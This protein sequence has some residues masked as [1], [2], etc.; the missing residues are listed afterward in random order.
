[1]EATTDFI[2]LLSFVTNSTSSIRLAQPST[3]HFAAI[4]CLLSSG[5]EIERLIFDELPVDYRSFPDFGNSISSS[6][7][8][9]SL[10][11]TN[12]IQW[13]W[14]SAA[15]IQDNPSVVVRML[16]NALRSQ[17]LRALSI[18]CVPVVGSATTE[19]LASAIS[20]SESLTELSLSNCA[21]GVGYFISKLQNIVPRLESL[22]LICN[23]SGPDA[24]RLLLG[25]NMR[26]L[27]LKN[28]MLE[29]HGGLELG[30]ALGNCPELRK[31]DLE[32]AS[33]TYQ[34]GVIDVAKGMLRRSR[35]R[36]LRL[37][38]LRLS[39][40]EHRTAAVV[41]LG[42]VFK[43]CPRLSD[44]SICVPHLPD[45][46]GAR[47]CRA[48]SCCA[49]T[50][51]R[52]DM[53]NCGLERKSLRA[54]ADSFAGG[55]ALRHLNLSHNHICLQGARKLL[56]LLSGAR[57]LES[58]S[59]VGC[60]IKEDGAKRLA[61]W[62]EDSETELKSLD[63]SDNPI[64]TYGAIALMNVIPPFQLEEINISSCKIGDA[65]APALIRIIERAKRLRSVKARKN[66]MRE[67]W[68]KV[69]Q[70]VMLAVKRGQRFDGLDLH[71]N[72]C[73]T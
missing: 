72:S 6:A 22:S 10:S 44:L 64:M 71:Y 66:E 41:D 35:G 62:L 52:L 23:G 1:M 33:G 9:T 5:A 68:I 16:A 18:T 51:L 63:V 17:S 55:C 48:L 56:R 42:N 8:I 54:L 65:A 15:A 36:A 31:L 30:E 4:S 73:S 38:S 45:P 67:Q 37:E 32:D 12:S 34:D 27:T 57:S 13:R 24:V 26:S 47:I 11:V 49:N 43:L 20:S 25:R 46:V 29:G 39:C 58:L 70:T 3:K 14:S 7:S 50:L 19:L 59:L 28:E 21:P 61:M 53:A 60:W 2:N 40:T 69:A